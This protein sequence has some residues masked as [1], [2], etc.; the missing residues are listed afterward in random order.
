MIK[1]IQCIRRRSELSTDEFLALWERYGIRLRDLA[2]QMGA[3]G[4]RISTTLDSPI[5]A[6]MAEARGARQA[7]DGVAEV[8]WKRRGELLANACDAV[9]RER[10]A[11]FRKSQEAFADIAYSQF[12][13]VHELDLFEEH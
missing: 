11:A 7:Y 10:L 2:L 4:A 8:L 12:F 5:N 13:F 6:A 3:S 1:L 9:T